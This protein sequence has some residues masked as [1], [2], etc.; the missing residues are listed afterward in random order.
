M[1][2][3]IYNKILYDQLEKIFNSA[4]HLTVIYFIFQYK[5]KIALV[6]KYPRSFN[7]AEGRGIEKLLRFPNKP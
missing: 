7:L 3:N 6:G 4:A 2:C 5:P 1:L